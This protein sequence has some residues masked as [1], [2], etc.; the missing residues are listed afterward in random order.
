MAKKVV[1]RKRPSVG[2]VLSHKFFGSDRNIVGRS[3]AIENMGVAGFKRSITFSQ[4]YFRTELNRF[5]N[6]PRGAKISL[7]KQ[8]QSLRKA[9]KGVKDIDIIVERSEKYFRKV[10]EIFDRYNI[11]TPALQQAQ[12]WRRLKFTKNWTGIAAPLK[13]KPV[14]QPERPGVP[15]V[16]NDI[17]WEP[18]ST[19]DIEGDGI[20]PAMWKLLSFINKTELY[21][22]GSFLVNQ[23][24]L[25]WI[26]ENDL[27]T[28]VIA[29]M[30]VE[31]GFGVKL[32]KITPTRE[33]YDL[34]KSALLEK[35]YNLKKTEQEI[36]ELPEENKILGY[37]TEEEF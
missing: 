34:A 14:P 4:K 25:N 1:K 30:E 19:A 35:W 5:G 15:G 6:V 3:D 2:R 23:Y 22:T 7:T 36:F 29:D 26:I 10:G 18:I 9:L 27:M 33:F 28:E 16:V 31:Q 21:S 12:P 11:E 20:P 24:T 13:P 37:D 32:Y 17:T 8:T